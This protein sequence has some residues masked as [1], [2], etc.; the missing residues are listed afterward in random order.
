MRYWLAHPFGDMTGPSA[1]HDNALAVLKAAWPD[2][3]R[4]DWIVMAGEDENGIEW[5]GCGGHFI[6]T[7]LNPFLE[8]PPTG[9]LAHMRSTNSTVSKMAGSPRCRR[10]GIF[11]R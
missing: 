7:F 3:E 1:F 2:V 5:V 6:G 4:R 9:H 11:P 8:I 10:S